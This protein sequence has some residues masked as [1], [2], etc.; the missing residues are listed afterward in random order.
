ME[1]I[2]AEWDKTRPTLGDETTTL[3]S[4]KDKKSEECSGLVDAQDD[5]E[6]AKEKAQEH[7]DWINV[8][9][10][11]NDAKLKELQEK[12]CEANLL[13]VEGLM[14]HK[15]S[16]VG[17]KVL[18]EILVGMEEDDIVGEQSAMLIQVYG[19]FS[20]L[21]NIMPGHLQNSFLEI[22]TNFDIDED[23]NMLNEKEIEAKTYYAPD[24]FALLDKSKLY[25]E[26]LILILLAA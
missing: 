22:S 14:E 17:I 5:I 21:F 23:F 10:S 4:I 25:I 15:Q 1:A 3:Q 8:R 13:F 16:L 2:D 6:A 9:T 11:D 20:K 26:F 24:K 12:R 19:S 7:L 18:R